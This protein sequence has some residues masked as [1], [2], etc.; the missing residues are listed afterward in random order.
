MTTLAIIHTTPATIASLKQLALE[1][2][3]GCTV[4]NFLDDSILSQLANNGG[5]L[6][7]VEE[8]LIVYARFA[9]QAGAD[10]ILEACSSAGEVTKKMRSV[11]KIPVVRI[12]DAMAEQVVV[13]ARTIGVAATLMTTLK[14]T[15]KLLEEKAAEAG[16]S[17]IL[18]PVLVNGDYQ[19]LMLG[20]RPGHDE[21]LVR[22]FSILLEE[23]DVIVLAQASMASVVSRMSVEV[24][25][26]I[27]S[28]PALAMEQVKQ[29]SR[30]D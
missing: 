14:P 21:E 12:D 26:R 19:K 17:N 9:E 30:K 29:L 1:V 4:I 25:S 3:P 6:T 8:R 27:Y 23:V 16:V 20:D 10:I 22:A 24:Q 15:M 18:K 11:V 7:Q 5:D 2:L 13:K 28:S